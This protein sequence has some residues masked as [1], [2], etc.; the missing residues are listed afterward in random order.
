MKFFAQIRPDGDVLP[1]RAEYNGGR[2]VVLGIVSGLP[3]IWE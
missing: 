1:V 3:T 2:N